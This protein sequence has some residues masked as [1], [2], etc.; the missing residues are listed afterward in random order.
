[1]LRLY[2]TVVIP[3]LIYNYE[4]WSNLTP[5]GYLTLQTSQLTYL[6]NVLEV[7]KATPIAAMYLELGIL[8]VRYEIEM[9]QLLFLKRIL[10]KKHD[11]PCLFTYNGM[12]KFENETNWEN[13]VLCLRRDYNLP[14]NDDSIK[15]MSVS[16]WKY[17]VK[18]A[19]FKEA[20]LQFQVELSSNRKTNHISYQHSF[21][22]PNDYLIKL[23]SH[24]ARLVFKAK[25]GCW[26]LRLII[27][28]NIKMVYI[29]Y[30]CSEYDETFEHIFK[31]NAG[32]RIPK[33]LKDFTL[34]SFSMAGSEKVF[35]KLGY[36]LGKYKNYRQEV[37]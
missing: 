9:R 22:K 13:N 29:V 24:L 11:D 14:L 7:S 37:M 17:F 15:K 21:L 5:K 30:Y 6:K 4:A 18:S 25:P 8:P 32:L 16:H 1:M 23:P 2:K 10:D 26:M 34:Q 28:E 31:C 36:F 3:R 33:Q 19:I 20:L 12:L 35:E 27:K